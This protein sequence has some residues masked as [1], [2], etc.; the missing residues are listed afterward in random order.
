MF[1]LNKFLIA[2][3]VYFSV[4]ITDTSDKVQEVGADRS[5]EEEDNDEDIFTKS[6]APYNLNLK[7]FLDIKGTE[8]NS[9]RTKKISDVSEIFAFNL[10][11]DKVI[12]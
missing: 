1:L 5:E 7:N 4:L 12:F 8:F 9:S 11:V 3:H 2:D 6:L 10:F